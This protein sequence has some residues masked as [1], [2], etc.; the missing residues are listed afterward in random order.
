MFP[1]AYFEQ[2]VDNLVDVID[3]TLKGGGVCRHCGLDR[4]KD[5]IDLKLLLCG[6]CRK[7]KYCSKDCQRAGW[8]AHKSECKKN[9]G[10]KKE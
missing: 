5:G 8:R 3:S 9:R 2:T 6:G 4:A 1:A 10:P 7:V